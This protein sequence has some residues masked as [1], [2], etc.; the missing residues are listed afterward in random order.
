M[1]SW[2]DDSALHVVV[3]GVR[4]YPVQWSEQKRKGGGGGKEDGKKEERRMVK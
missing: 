3:E 2:C 1:L 4:R